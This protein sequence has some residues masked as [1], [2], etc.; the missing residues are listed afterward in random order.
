MFYQIF[1][2]KEQSFWCTIYKEI[3]L[4][5]SMILL[6]FNLDYSSKKD[7]T[8]KVFPFALTF[9]RCYHYNTFPYIHVCIKA[10]L[11]LHKQ[12]GA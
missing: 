11:F 1:K 6:Y 8:G 7:K 3:S 12:E 4:S 5:D 2:A 9:I 10:D